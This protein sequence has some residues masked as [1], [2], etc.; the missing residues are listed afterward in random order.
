F[1]GGLAAPKGGEGYRLVVSDRGCGV[2]PETLAQIGK[3]FIQAENS[4][5]RGYQGT[6]LGLA[7]SYRLAQSMGGSIAIE[8][9][10][11]RGT[12]ATLTLR[13][14]EAEQAVPK[15]TA[16]GDGKPALKTQWVA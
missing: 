15:S 8:S 13:A 1:R 7:I 5:V 3:P 10:V 6:G 14:V 4:Y 12:R 11:G 2:P 16:D 9:E